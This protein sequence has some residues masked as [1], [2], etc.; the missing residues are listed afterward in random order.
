MVE[1]AHRSHLNELQRTVTIGIRAEFDHE[2]TGRDRFLS[3]RAAIC[4][5]ARFSVA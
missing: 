1:L 5:H 2:K 3:Y 4:V